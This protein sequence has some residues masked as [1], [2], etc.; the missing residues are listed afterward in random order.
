M[1]KMNDRAVRDFSPPESASSFSS[2][3]FLGFAFII[4]PPENGSS[5]SSRPMNASPPPESWA[6]IDLKFSFTAL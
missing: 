2:L 5:S 4:R 3:P 1:A 6:Y